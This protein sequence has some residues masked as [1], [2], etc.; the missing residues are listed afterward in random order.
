MTIA[1]LN[2]MNGVDVLCDC[3]STLR[4]CPL[5]LV[6]PDS[7]WTCM[8]CSTTHIGCDLLEDVETTQ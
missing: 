2:N 5:E 6:T 4:I 1:T 7:E 8:K 3:G